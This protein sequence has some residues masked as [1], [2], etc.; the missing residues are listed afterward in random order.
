M[1]IAIRT[2]CSL[3]AVSLLGCAPAQTRSIHSGEIEARMQPD[4][5]WSLALRPA[6]WEIHGHLPES[7]RSIQVAAASDALG[8]YQEVAAR[9]DARTAAIR[10]YE[11]SGNVL[12]LDEYSRQQTNHSPFP[13]LDSLPATLMRFGYQMNAFGQ[14]EF[15]RAGEEGPWLL[16]DRNRN[17]MVLS[18][19]DNF[20]VS[21]MQPG[22]SAALTSG[23][24][25]KIATLPAG[26][27]HKTLLVF[28]SGIN[29]TFSAW[30][31]SLLALGG[32]QPVPGDADA[33]LGKLGYWTDNGADYYYKYEP[34]LGYQGTLLA[35]R[36]QFRKAAV[37]I[38]YEQ[39]DSWWYPKGQG[40]TKEGG[41]MELRAD[42]EAFSGPLSAF[43]GYLG[44][45][46]A[47]HARW[48]DEK[49]P[50]RR[51]FR[52]SANVILSAD[53][54]N[55]LAASL[56]DSGVAVYEQDWL[57]D[58]ARP[59]VNLTDPEE[60][61]GNMSSAMEHAGIAIQYCMPLPGHYLASTQFPAV[62]TIRTSPDRFGPSRY[63]FFLYGSALAHAV[64]LWPWTDVF[65]SRE[66]NNLV[67]ATL[68][69]GPVGV[70]DR[71]GPGR[72]RI[73]IPPIDSAALQRAIRSDSVLLKP[74]AP[75]LPVDA[76]YLSDASSDARNTPM[77]AA[78]A[79]RF[80]SAS[81]MYVLAYARGSG[82]S[83]A[84]I[85]LDDLGMHGAVYAWNWRTAKAELLHPHA[86]LH[87][88]LTPSQ[89][90]EA[91]DGVAWG[92]AV[93]APSDS[94]GL[95]LLG[96]ASKIVPLARKRFSSVTDGGAI[97][98]A[99][100]FSPG[101]KSITITGFATRRPRITALTGSVGSLQYNPA[102]RVF[103]FRASPPAAAPAQ[104][105]VRIE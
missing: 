28:G 1:R 39:L 7:A 82:Q 67:I 91:D 44:L 43:H 42:P 59:A 80:A 23:I 95:A 101:E 51:S 61:L 18:P 71:I 104:A 89:T 8:R 57:N 26:F 17:T 90:A 19:A 62:R 54:W 22:A 47:V 53:Y 105:R 45:P 46:F 74:D 68:S 93:L 86:A 6:H 69:G 77:I 3:L 79:T 58:K 35:V 10:I 2:L 33:I 66:L 34:P 85:P 87:I 99:I 49:S 27:T 24:D 97:E 98:A 5:R 94:H 15:G 72:G 37:P 83:G 32:K 56:K 25:P 12:F 70:G 84:E 55:R 20:L 9:Y 103:T 50:L 92:Y 13:S 30:G 38:A 11:R 73:R 52:M 31:Q 16:F 29:R 75:L 41:I 40:N 88:P 102:S 100:A 81:E 64:G 65:M 4:G 48:I 21:A 36:D 96:D 14:Y 63:D 78:T 76:L 60:F